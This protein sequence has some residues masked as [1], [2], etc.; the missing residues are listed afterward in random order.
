[1]YYDLNFFREQSANYTYSSTQLCYAFVI[2][3]IQ[4]VNQL[5][6]ARQNFG[7]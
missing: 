1:M 7:G 2:A 4:S 5:E 6:L 3:F